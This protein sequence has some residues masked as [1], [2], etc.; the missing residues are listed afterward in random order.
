LASL[1]EPADG[2]P[3]ALSRATKLWIV[4]A[5]LFGCTLVIGD[6]VFRDH[7]GPTAE[8][9]ATRARETAQTRVEALAN[10]PGN[11]V[12]RKQTAEN[13]V[14]AH[15]LQLARL[16]EAVGPQL[17][18]RCTPEIRRAL[19]SA[20]EDYVESRANAVRLAIHEPIAKDLDLDKIWQTDED[21]KALADAR[22]LLN[23]GYLVASEFESW[24]DDEDA[25]LPLP[26][27][28]PSACSRPIDADDP[29]GNSQPH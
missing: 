22:S 27:G 13:M 10:Q 12:W 4:A 3:P 17:A 11:I 24:S 2:R 18:S 1:T 28:V 5:V 20:L 29:V 6:N 7:G 21:A 15:T 16:N 8:E 25:I 9:L 19:R 14:G 26:N 23:Q